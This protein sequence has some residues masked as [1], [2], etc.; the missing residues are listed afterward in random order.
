MK[1]YRGLW[2]M[3]DYHG[4]SWT[5][6]YHVLLWIIV[7]SGRSWYYKYS[8]V[9]WHYH[10]F[11]TVMVYHGLPW[12]MDYHG[13]FWIIIDYCELSKFCRSVMDDGLSWTSMG[14]CGLLRIIVNYQD[15][16]GL[17]I[18]MFHIIL[19]YNCFPFLSYIWEPISHRYCSMWSGT[20]LNPCG[21][22][23][24]KLTPNRGHLERV[25]RNSACSNFR[26]TRL[27]SL[28]I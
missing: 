8:G 24:I 17:W 22:T 19:I 14:Y 25:W 2:T 27:I 9:S 1:D 6:D 12:T 3:M 23:S 15:D 11:W 16:H 7:D 5:M 28:L 26:V 18:I 20:L 4:L 13:L 21:G 10:E